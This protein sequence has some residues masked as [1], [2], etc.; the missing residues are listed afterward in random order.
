MRKS[1]ILGALA[2][3]MA[4]IF[5]ACNINISHNLGMNRVEDASE[6]SIDGRNITNLELSV[7]VGKIEISS[8]DKNEISVNAI[9]INNGFKDRQELMDEL[10]NIEIQYNQDGD[11][12]AV[13][14]FLPKFKDNGLSVDLSVSVPKTVTAYNIENE[15]GDIELS[16]LSGNIDGS[17]GVGKV[18]M[19]DCSGSINFNVATGDI[20]LRKCSLKGSCNISGATGRLLFDGTIDNSGTYNLTTNVGL[21]EITLPKD[22][23]FDIDASSDVGGIS[24]GFKVDGELKKTKASGKVNGGGP[25]L[26]LVNNIGG[27]KINDR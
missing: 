5:C 12:Y 23:A 14:V 11:K 18:D 3:F 10:N 15:V 1:F 27:I 20:Q 22:A 25:K 8:W 7:P 16:D 19:S 26:T 24:C 9:K 13:K 21:L 4:V 17:G 2:V 6:R